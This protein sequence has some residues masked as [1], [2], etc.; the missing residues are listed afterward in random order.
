VGKATELTVQDLFQE[1]LR[2]RG[3][4]V[5]SQVSFETPVGRMQPD[6]VLRNGAQY[7]VETKLGAETKLLDAMVQ[8]YDYSK[9][10]PE[11]KGAFAVLFP[12]ELRRPW[13]QEVIERIALDPKT[14]YNAIAIF[15]DFRP[16]QPFKGSLGELADW[17]S[18]HVFRVP[19]VEA[20]T[21][22]AIRVLR[23]AVSYVTASVRMLKGEELEDIF[24]GK[25][26]FENILQYKEGRYPLEEMRQAATYL[27]VN[28]I[29]FYHVLSSIDRSFETINEDRIDK[30]EDLVKYFETVLKKDY[31]SV[32]GFDVVS[33]LPENA[34]DVIKKVVMAIKALAPQ[35][36]RHDI[37]GKVFHELIPFEV[38]KAVAAF[39]TNNEAAEILAQL[40]IDKPDAKVID[41]AV[42]SGTLLVAAYR[43]KRDLLK[44]AKGVVELEELQKSFI[45]K[46]LTGIDVMPFAAHL[47]VVALSLQAV[48][49][50]HESEKVRIAVW[51]ST[52]LKPGQIIPA[53]SRELKEA[54]KRPTLEM[55]MKG[56]Q[57]R[58][59]AYI[60]KGAVTL[61]GFGGEQMTLEKADLVIMNPP[62]TRQERLPKEYKDALMNRLRK[63]RNFLHGQLGLYGY[64]ILLADKFA[65]KNGTIALV[66]PAT[67]LRVQSA[68]GIRE[69]L[70]ENYTINYIVTA[71]Q[72]LAFSESAKFR[73]ILLVATKTKDL[74][75]RGVGKSSLPKCTI[76]ILKELPKNLEK[77]KNCAAQ[78]KTIADSSYET[79]EN[80]S[81]V[82][83]KISQ[84]Q[85][86]SIVDNM[87]ILI[88]VKNPF[89]IQMWEKTKNKAKNK[90]TIFDKYLVETKSEIIRGIET[91][92]GGKVQSLTILVDESMAIKKSDIWIAEDV[93]KNS[94]IAKHRFFEKRIRIPI[95][96]LHRA[97]RRVSYV[98]RLD[99]TNNL[100]Y[101]VTK[102]FQNFE[103]FLN[104]S[105]MDKKTRFISQWRKYVKER[106]SN[107]TIARRFNISAPGTILLA[108]YSSIPAAPPGVSWSLNISQDH[109]KILTLWFNSS[110]NLL[111]TLIYRKETGG[112]YSQIDKYT[113]KAFQI[114]DP[115][116]LSK[117]EKKRL[118][119]IFKKVKKINFPSILEQLKTRFQPRIEIDKVI[120]QML[121]F[122]DNEIDRMLNNLYPA[123]ANEIEQLKTLM[124]G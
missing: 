81:L 19:V 24:G 74:G 60:K 101:V 32:F 89:L 87:F 86:R 99:V 96:S 117:S 43:R 103:E 118:L 4:K 15:K 44:K 83:Y 92:H 94:L 111:Q 49:A 110:L 68:K 21:G 114:L 77:A 25:S 46:D 30:P 9:Y 52:E 31:T 40:A 6:I 61:E 121:G 3:V 85:L 72:R 112:A 115:T 35:K 45:E 37:L 119:N 90:F 97:I 17:I 80:K 53:I 91:S 102:K 29:L 63:Y 12:A 124:E 23:D 11:S 116:S 65:K 47:A 54:Y 106:L 2:K 56:E 122:T 57:S 78:I 7:V 88:S 28:Q 108:F 41:L 36:I 113:L 13:P 64:F 105:S 42:G 73:E 26:V 66:L 58:E 59:D 69:L 98:K 62:F 22:F 51:D 20:D 39:Y 95:N 10:V 79:Y 70:T 93:S 1:E 82:A 71:Q 48:M 55:F 123:L 18:S 33:R 34:A 8:L 5:A 100:D 67:I 14:Q 107:F 50:G 76:I 104:L 75:G 16:S 27:L 38:R 109:A 120:L 84:K